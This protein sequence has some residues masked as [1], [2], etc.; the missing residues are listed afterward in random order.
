MQGFSAVER[1]LV[2]WL[3]RYGA[4]LLF[5]AQVFGIVGLPIPD[6]LLMMVA[7][8]LVKQGH[9]RGHSITIA[10]IAG[11]LCGI[12]VSYLVG[13]LIDVKVLHRKFPRHQAAIKRA[14]A[15]FRRFEGWLLAFGYFIPGVRNVSAI[16]AGSSELRYREFALYAYTGGVFWCSVYLAIGYYAGDHW[17][18]VADKA[19]SNIT[20]TVVILGCAVAMLVVFRKMAERR[21]IHT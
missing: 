12:T 10:A 16:I 3:T 11:C 17:E 7:G 20:L 9:L 1:E 2:T 5:F 8:A 13:V 21:R 15:W 18:E 4:P 14:Q 19:R 6:E